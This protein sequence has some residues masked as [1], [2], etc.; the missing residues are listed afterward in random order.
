M[1]AVL[2]AGA[3]GLVVRGVD[4]PRAVREMLEQ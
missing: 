2:A 4:D 1:R 3:D